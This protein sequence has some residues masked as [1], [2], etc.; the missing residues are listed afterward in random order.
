MDEKELNRF[1][2]YPTQIIN[3]FFEVLEEGRI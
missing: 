3:S 2:A 1:D